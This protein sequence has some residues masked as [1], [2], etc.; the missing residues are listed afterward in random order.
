[1]KLQNAI[2]GAVKAD[3]W[4]SPGGFVNGLV[5]IADPDDYIGSGFKILSY[6]EIEAGGEKFVMSFKKPGVSY[7]LLGSIRRP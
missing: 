6:R 3:M 7:Q 5:G 1:M 2:I 4:S